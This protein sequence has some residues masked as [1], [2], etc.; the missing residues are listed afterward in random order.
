MF[1]PQD[2]G[3]ALFKGW[4]DEQRRA[5]LERLVT[6]YR[7]GLPLGILCKMAETVAGDESAAREALC[8]IMSLE[9]RRAAVAAETGAIRMVAEKLLL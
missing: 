5:E 7:N 4:T 1:G 8:A 2:L 6:G 9:E 3:A